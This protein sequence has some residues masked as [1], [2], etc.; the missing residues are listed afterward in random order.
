MAAIRPFR[1]AANR[2]S[3]IALTK[4][5]PTEYPLPYVVWTPRAARRPARSS[6]AGRRGRSIAAAARLSPGRFGWREWTPPIV[7]AGPSEYTAHLGANS[8]G[9]NAVYWFE[10]LGKQGDAVRVR[11]LAARAKRSVPVGEHLLEPELALSAAPLG[12][13]ATLVGAAAGAH[14]A[15]PRPRTRERASKKRRCG[16]NYPLTHRYLRQF[17]PSLVARAAYRRYQGRHAFLFDVQCRRVHPGRGEGGLAADGS[18]DQ[19]GRSRGNRRP[20]LGPPAGRS[21]RDV[22]LGGVRIGR[23]GALPCAPCSTARRSTNWSPRTA[24]RR[25]GFWDAERV[26]LFSAFAVLTPATRGTRRWPSA[27]AARTGS[28]RNCW[29]DRRRRRRSTASRREA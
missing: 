5:P 16:A 11:N 8:G 17:E 12:R 28:Q 27:V 29:T 10:L 18:A 4:G 24:L 19:R 14:P 3:T 2:T 9:A 6:V 23:R 26:G 25:Q 20:A 1:R 13:R 21:A 7:P 22:R 15:C